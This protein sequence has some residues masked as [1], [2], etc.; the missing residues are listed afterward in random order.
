[1]A[2]RTQGNAT[3]TRS[4][5][6]TRILNCVPSPRPETDWRLHNAADAGLL[7]AGAR[8]VPAA[9]DL[10]EDSWWR[11]G[12]Q[13]DTGSCVG[14]ATAD[15]VLRWHFVQA[16]RLA[17]NQ[18]LST[19]FQWM[20]AKETDHFVAQ[21][22]T[23][24]ESDGTSLKAALDVSRK[25]GAVRDAVLPFTSGKLYEGEVA[26]FYAIATQ[27]KIAAY[28]NV[29]TDLAGWRTW[30]AG[31]GPILTRLDVDST[32]DNATAN[33]GKL[34]TYRPS[35]A[36]GGHAVALVGYTS[37]GFIVRNSWGTGWGDKGYAY[38]SNAY[39]R[40]AFTE[41]YGVTL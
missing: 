5:G 19:R 18:K 37:T 10:R 38:A 26:T 20:A 39:A 11:I 30:L 31:S 23:F 22:T 40:K 25:W 2:A 35:T 8:A 15:S 12:D 17:K 14:W 6:T 4:T 21:P 34:T 29:G 24:I 7:A 28:F 9:K 33:K 13:G 41:A 27:L 1:M 36:R 32:W 16:G 3:S